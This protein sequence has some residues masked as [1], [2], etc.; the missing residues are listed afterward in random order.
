MGSCS[1]QGGMAG[2][3]RQ[4]LE[5]INGYYSHQNLGADLS[6]YVAVVGA[7][8]R[9]ASHVFGL[10][11]QEVRYLKSKFPPRTSQENPNTPATPHHPQHGISVPASSVV[12]LNALGY[13]GFK[14]VTTC[15]DS[16][17]YLWTLERNLDADIQFQEEVL[18]DRKGSEGSGAGKARK[19]KESNGKRRHS[20]SAKL[21]FLH[22]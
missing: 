18:T 13:I 3:Y 6:S 7:P 12:L 1:Q 2:Y 10:T 16:Q 4:Q 9:D 20:L 19:G 5:D 21:S 11:P 15:G 8:T 14:V 22:L 17:E